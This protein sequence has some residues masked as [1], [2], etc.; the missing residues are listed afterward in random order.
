[1]QIL[2]T[3]CCGFIGFS[4]AQFLLKK[5]KNTEIIG[6]DSLDNYYSTTLKKNR[7]KILKSYKK[8]FIFHKQNLKNFQ[9]LENIFKNKKIKK[10][11]HFAAQA[12]VRY[13]F[14]KPKKYIDSNIIS[15]FNVLELSRKYNIKNVYFA[16]SSS[17]YGDTKKLPSVEGDIS[18]EKNLYAISKNFNEKFAKIYS[19]K[20]NM[21]II[22]LR[23]FTVYGEWGRP[24]MFMIKYMLSSKLKKDFNLYNFGNH[25]RDFTY[26]NDVVNIVYKVSNL[27]IK[28]NY[29]IF[30]ICSSKPLHLNK[31]MALLNISLGKVNIIKKKRDFADVLDTHGSNKKIQKLIGKYKFTKIEEGINNLVTWFNNYYKK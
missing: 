22:G 16:S 4:Y 18:Q 15:F 27:K 25:K 1:M 29:D 31:I 7:L 19:E 9:K 5:Y 10:L 2:I 26:I 23:F 24:D 30:N 28:K 3:G 8:R 6:I 12:G 21:K 14:I 13:S 20:Y 11:F 17:I